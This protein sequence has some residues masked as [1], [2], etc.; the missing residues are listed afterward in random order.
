MCLL[1]HVY[2]T[3]LQLP[4]VL[5]ADLKLILTVNIDLVFVMG[6]ITPIKPLL[7]LF[8]SSFQFWQTLLQTEILFQISYYFT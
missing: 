6:N 8:I 4:N 1:Q 7:I 3:N 5:A 2:L